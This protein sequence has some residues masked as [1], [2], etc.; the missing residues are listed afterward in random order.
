MSGTRD[1]GGAV[2]VTRRGPLTILTIN[3]PD[4]NNALDDAVRAAL[5]RACDRIAADADAGA[6]L[7]TGAGEEAFSTGYDLPQLAAL[8][9]AEAE[10]LARAAG[11]ACARLLV[12]EPQPVYRA[13]LQAAE[14]CGADLI[15]MGTHGMGLMERIFVGSQTQ[16]VL[17][18]TRIPVL[19]FH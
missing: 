9:P 10:A 5:L 1:E 15:V 8:T 11:V 3:R 7:L 2:R 13:I 14:D 18:H 12:R 19:T 4:A 16:R 17:A 6:V